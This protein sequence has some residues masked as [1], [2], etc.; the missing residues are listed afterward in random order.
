M[1]QEIDKYFELYIESFSGKGPL[2]FVFF[3][4]FFSFSLILLTLIFSPLHRDAI[5]DDLLIKRGLIFCPIIAFSTL[6]LTRYVRD[7]SIN[8]FI[9]DDL[10]FEK[11][12][13]DDIYKYL[14]LVFSIKN[15]EN[16]KLNKLKCLIKN[17]L[18]ISLVLSIL[19]GVSTYISSENG[20]YGI[21]YRINQDGLGVATGAFINLMLVFIIINILNLLRQISRFPQSDTYC[22]ILRLKRLWSYVV[23]IL[24]VYCFSL[25]MSIPIVLISINEGGRLERYANILLLIGQVVSFFILFLA[26]GYY[27]YS[28][29]KKSKSNYLEERHQRIQQLESRIIADSCDQNGCA[30]FGALLHNVEFV[31]KFDELPSSPETVKIILTSI[32]SIIS[33]LINYYRNF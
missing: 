4:L 31:G 19:L 9:R 33:I 28:M 14:V 17:Q 25:L 7:I 15:T 24:F 10:P 12:I 13:R 1:V 26:P 30:I 6:I 16:I 23:C 21:V 2:S 22:Q 11:E 18:T 8:T 27:V 29:I 3:S 20:V 5:I 32:L